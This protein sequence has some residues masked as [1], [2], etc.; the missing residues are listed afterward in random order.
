LDRPGKA[1]GIPH[2]QESE[3]NTA[4]LPQYQCHK[5]VRAAKIAAIDFGERLDLMPH[6]IVEVGAQWI[7]EK[8]AHAGGY[9][10]IY[11]DGFASYSPAKAFEEGYTL[12]PTD[13][14]DR[15]RAEAQRLA[16]DFTKLSA[17]LKTPLFESLADAEKIRMHRQHGHM[18]G[19][20]S[21]LRDRIEAFDT[22]ETTERKGEML[23]EDP[24]H[25]SV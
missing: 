3:L 9:Y 23:T 20:L 16:E 6:G 13:H 21:S 4:E 19:Y 14:R 15:V 7:N 12:I 10:V 24:D 5:K 18:G 11:E 22:P 1:A 2:Q 8:R 25:A 17:F